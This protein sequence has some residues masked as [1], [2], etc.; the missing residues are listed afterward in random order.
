MAAKGGAIITDDE[1]LYNKLIWYTQHQ[2]RQK[3]IF[4]FEVNNF[5]LNCR[6]N[7]FTAI[8]IRYSMG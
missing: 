7:P 4:G 6:I 2:D 1:D 5:G 3:K 8:V